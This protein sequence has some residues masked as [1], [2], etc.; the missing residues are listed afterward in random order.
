[1]ACWK[2]RRREVDAPLAAS[3]LAKFAQRERV[4]SRPGRRLH[5]QAVQELCQTF[6]LD[7]LVQHSSIKMRRE[8][9]SNASKRHTTLVAVSS[10]ASHTRTIPNSLLFPTAT[11][12]ISVS[13]F[14]L[15]I[16]CCAYTTVC[17]NSRAKPVTLN[18]VRLQDL[19]C[20]VSHECRFTVQRTD[21][22]HRGTSSLKISCGESL[23]NR[24][25]LVPEGRG[26]TLG[27]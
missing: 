6:R 21:T 19:Q 20:L 16:M 12:H 2:V 3:S 9:A 10:K 5:R 25:V 8:R 18:S 24:F 1:M 7:S 11:R 27:G 13:H 26:R 23:I 22:L 14:T 4:Y 17:C 15:R